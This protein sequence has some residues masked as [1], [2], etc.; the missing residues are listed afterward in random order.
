MKISCLTWNTAKRLKYVYDQ[1]NLIQQTNPD[2]VAL[3]EVI[4]S[5]DK[6]FKRLLASHYPHIASSFDLALD[7][8]VLTKKRMFG[9]IIASNKFKVLSK[10]YLHNQK[11][12][13]DYSPMQ[14]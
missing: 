5:S 7:M 6:K 12:I 14:V 8:S 9:Q 1:V 3:Q 13:S 11:K 2:I 4:I 10:K